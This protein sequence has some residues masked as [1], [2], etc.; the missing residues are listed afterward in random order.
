MGRE[1]GGGGLGGTWL[2]FSFSFS[3]SIMSH[4]SNKER[5]NQYQMNARLTAVLSNWTGAAIAKSTTATTH[6]Q[7][8]SHFQGT[9]GSG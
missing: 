6:M 3:L 9:G 8:N 1:G 5:S 4:Q 2:G 7:F